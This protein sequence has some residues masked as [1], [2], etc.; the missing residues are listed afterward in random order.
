M[1]Y[2]VV[3]NVPEKYRSCDMRRHFKQFT[4]AGWFECF[5]YR[6][7]P[8]TTPATTAN[9]KPTCC[10]VVRVLDGQGDK[11]L[12]TYHHKIWWREEEQDMENSLGVAVILQ[13]T[14]TE[15]GKLLSLPE[16]NPPAVMKKGNVGTPT[17]VFLDLVQRC[18]LPP[19][20]IKKLKLEFPRTIK[21]KQYS[22]VPP[23]MGSWEYPAASSIE[24]STSHN[25]PSSSS[26]QSTS[27]ESTKP[28][29]SQKPTESKGDNGH[30][31]GRGKRRKEESWWSEEE[32]KEEHDGSEDWERHE[33]FHNDVGT[34]DR[35]KQKLFEEDMEI[36][37]DKG[38]SGLVFYTDANFWADLE[39]K[40]T[41]GLWADEWDVDMGVYEGHHGDK[42]A[43]D[44]AE[45]RESEQFRKFGDVEEEVGD[46][47]R[48]TKGF[49][50]RI[51]RQQGWSAGDGLGRST[52]GMIEPI[53]AE[54]P[55]HPRD[56]GVESIRTLTSSDF[57]E[58]SHMLKYDN[59]G[60]HTAYFRSE[61]FL[62][63]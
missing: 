48:H 4:E 11:F 25:K 54:N 36:V 29:T 7:R 31:K 10:C 27:K 2:F 19:P 59:G 17:A 39:G 61:K 1:V 34:Q 60:T 44:T 13:R 30:D 55:K 41:D 38:S 45:K 18:K 3:S 49:G 16:L 35:T 22:A 33:T 62:V 51:M 58:T 40:D 14:K 63:R 28:S 24:H 46:F 53:T 8:E 43:T 50:G 21:R 37:W 42:D 9:K 23:I 52:I 15:L 47:E 57:S 32:R 5:H 6:H 56:K 20:I 26:G 12:D